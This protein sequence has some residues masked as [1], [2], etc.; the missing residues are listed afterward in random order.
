MSKSVVLE[1]TSDARQQMVVAAAV[2]AD[3]AGHDAHV[4]ISSRNC[5]IV[6]RTNVADQHQSRQPSLRAQSQKASELTDVDPMVPEVLNR[7]GVGPA[8]QREHHDAAPLPDE[9]I[10]NRRWQ[11]AAAANDRQPDRWISKLRHR[12]P[13]L[14]SSA[15]ARNSR[16]FAFRPMNRHGERARTGAHELDDLGDLRMIAHRLGHLIEA[17][18]ERSASKEQRL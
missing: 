7:S 14:N 12:Q 13:Q 2:G 17:L 10:G 4:S 5:W 8:V 1:N 15:R 18:R 11:A 3:D 9:R 16:R 6:G